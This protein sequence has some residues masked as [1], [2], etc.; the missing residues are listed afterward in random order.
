[1]LIPVILPNTKSILIF[2]DTLNEWEIEIGS[3]TT[4]RHSEMIR[5]DTR[6]LLSHSFGHRLQIKQL[7]HVTLFKATDIE[8]SS[9]LERSM[10]SPLQDCMGHPVSL[11]RGVQNGGCPYLFQ[12]WL[13]TKP[14]Q[15]YIQKHYKEYEL[16]HGMSLL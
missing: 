7:R 15:Q 11:L 4:M 13:S 9:M 2:W 14:L 3:A 8:I 5:D 12:D 16:S 10:S 6:V 1:M